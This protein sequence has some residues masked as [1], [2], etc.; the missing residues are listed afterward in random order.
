MR[1]LKFT[2]SY[3]TAVLDFKS[4]NM[5]FNSFFKIVENFNG[6]KNEKLKSLNL[7]DGDIKIINQNFHKEKQLRNISKLKNILNEK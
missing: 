7:A 3:K 1:S 6:I 4:A 5:I 2:L